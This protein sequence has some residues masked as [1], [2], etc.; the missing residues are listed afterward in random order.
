MHRYSAARVALASTSVPLLA[1]VLFWGGC[2]YVGSPVPPATNIPARVT[3]LAAVQRDARIIVHFLLPTLTT[4]GL[5]IRPPITTELRIGPSDTPPD[6]L[7]AVQ[8]GDVSKGLATY[9]I[10]STDWTGKEVAINA[11]TL[12]ANGKPSAWADPVTLQVVAAPPVPADFKVE[13]TAQG[14]RLTW[15]GPAG[16][17][18]VFRKAGDEQDFSKLADVQQMQFT[19][20]GTEYGKHYTYTAQRIVRLEGGKE[21]ESNP[22]TEREITPA[23]KFPPA[24][25]S[26]L[27][28]AA[29]PESVELT[30]EQD[31]DSDLAG[32]RVYRAVGDGA[33]ERVA[34]VSQVPA[35]SDRAVEHGKTY[36]YAVSA[37]DQVGNESQRSAPVEATLQ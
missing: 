22:A 21:A 18:R 6:Q 9:E 4:E 34:E 26:G 5:V 16:D 23:D 37:F 3:N 11:R 17:F 13:G 36:R 19:D 10:P 27:H 32:Y 15:Q 35:Y 1:A 14:V 25:P 28:A 31:T 29:A 30:W 20:A 33:F 2:A 8:G 24:V 12:G 7:Q